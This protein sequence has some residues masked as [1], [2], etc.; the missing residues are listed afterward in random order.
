M[1][2]ALNFARRGQVDSVVLTGA[3]RTRPIFS[4]EKQELRRQGSRDV[5]CAVV[6]K[7]R[8]AARIQA[9]L[10]CYCTQS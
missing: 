4:S 9:E 5:L 7:L 6:H 10:L 8:M 1:G 2:Q 3:L